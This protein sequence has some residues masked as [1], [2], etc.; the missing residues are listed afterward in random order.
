MSPLFLTALLA[1]GPVYAQSSA[2]SSDRATPED[3]VRAGLS[4]ELQR[5]VEELS[6]DDAD[7]PYFIAYRLVERWRGNIRA[8][9]GAVDYDHALLDRDL[10]VEARVGSVEDDSA[11]F[12]AGFRS[13]QGIVR[14]QLVMGD[15]EDAIRKDAWLAT[16]EAYKEAV[17]NLSAK[18]AADARR[19]SVDEDPGPPEFTIPSPPTVHSAAPAEKPRLGDLRERIVAVSERFREHRGLALSSA[20]GDAA[21]GRV[22][23]LDSG[24]TDVQRPY[25]LASIGFSA[26]VLAEDGTRMSDGRRWHARTVDELPDLAALHAEA[27]AMAASLIAWTD[28]EIPTEPLIGPVLIEGDAAVQLFRELL[29]PALEGTPP[30]QRP[31][32][33]SRMFDFGSGS[34]TLGV[35]R[36]LL[37]PGWD[38]RDDPAIAPDSPAAVSHDAEGTPVEPI[39]LVVD[40]IVKTH[41]ASRTPSDSV[42]TSN[43]H[44]LLK[45]RSDIVR[46]GAMVTAVRPRKVQSDK[47][48]HKLAMKRAAAYG[49]DSYIVIRRFKEGGNL[50]RLTLSRS[51]DALST[52]VEIVRVTRD[53]SETRLRNVAL[54]GLDRRALRDIA[55]A[56]VSSDLTFSSGISRIHLEAPTVLL[57][58][59]EV[60]PNR[61]SV[62]KPPPLDPPLA[63]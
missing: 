31:S 55:A 60:K 13:K 49:N 15:V 54:D 53:G 52:P 50:G 20:T 35:K 25:A 12:A 56:G 7:P 45:L 34:E 14:R 32:K 18:Q 61:E 24:G 38:V 3:P 37:P 19:S 1:S 43:G 36:R 23:V 46:G 63:R 48:L 2:Q 41:Y 22:L 5:S 29:L 58:E 6:L 39:D 10:I 44:G 42:R 16:D 33:G 4:A 47:K 57:E 8:S 28:A 40:G 30:K 17:E 27:D 11:N 21:G 51:S 62:E 26:Q 59:L 9:L